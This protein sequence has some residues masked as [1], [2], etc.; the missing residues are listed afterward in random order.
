MGL[1]YGLVLGIEAPRRLELRIRTE[2]LD[3]VR[4][5]VRASTGLGLWLS[6]G[7]MAGMALERVL[8]LWA[9]VR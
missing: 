6:L 2:A 7:P 4:V 1:C 3:G 8:G 5:W 9:Q